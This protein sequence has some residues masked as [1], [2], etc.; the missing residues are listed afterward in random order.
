MIGLG[1]NLAFLCLTVVPEAVSVGPVRAVRDAASAV[2]G[3]LAL[4]DRLGTAVA[5]ALTMVDGLEARAKISILYR[6]ETMDRY[7]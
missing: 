7:Q 1:I 3:R 4:L 6:R 5:D 2:D